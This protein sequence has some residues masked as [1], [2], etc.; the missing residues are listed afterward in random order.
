M[1]RHLVPLDDGPRAQIEGGAVRNFSPHVDV[2]RDE[3]PSIAGASTVSPHLVNAEGFSFLYKEHG[4]VVVQRQ[5]PMTCPDFGGLPVLILRTLS[6]FYKFSWAA[7][8]EDETPLTSFKMECHQV[9]VPLIVKLFSYFYKSQYKDKDKEKKS[10]FHFQ[11]VSSVP[12]I[13]GELSSKMKGRN[14]SFILIISLKSDNL[15]SQELA[16]VGEMVSPPTTS[17]GLTGGSAMQSLM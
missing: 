5:L 1:A 6:L 3:N 2:S 9:G 14:D 13:L 4:R 8:F 10:Y 7:M 15:S 12:P 17:V 11:K 16:V